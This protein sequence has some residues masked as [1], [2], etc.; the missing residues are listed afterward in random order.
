MV[1]DYSHFRGRKKGSERL[2]DLLKVAHMGGTELILTPLLTHMDS[3]KSFT[4]KQCGSGEL[5]G[6]STVPRKCPLGRVSYL[7]LLTKQ[8]IL[9]L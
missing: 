3:V 9:A 1:L 4:R 5:L 8:H 6:G 7:L 2:S